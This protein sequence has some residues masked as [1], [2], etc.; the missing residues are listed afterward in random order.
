M[1]SVTLRVAPDHPAFAGHFPGQPLLPGVVL[2]A[3]VLEAALAQPAL[4]AA[5][6]P[7]PRIGVAKFLAP[8]RPGVELTLQLTT[9]A[10][11]LR[12]EAWNG[13]Q[14]AASGSFEAGESR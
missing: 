8:V 14:L 1:H 10:G 7:A 5:L 11:G 4:A 9:A 6:G 13:A 12:F 2:L 3:E